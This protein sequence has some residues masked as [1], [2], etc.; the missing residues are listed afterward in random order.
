MQLRGHFVYPFRSD[1]VCVFRK[2]S[3]WFIQGCVILEGSGILFITSDGPGRIK[4]E[5][6]INSPITIPYALAQGSGD[7]GIVSLFALNPDAKSGG[8]NLRPATWRIMAIFQLG[9]ILNY[10][11][12]IIE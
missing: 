6:E 2:K 8:V 4:R 11:N 3:H 5:G 10:K 7:G 1:N 12:S 9:Y